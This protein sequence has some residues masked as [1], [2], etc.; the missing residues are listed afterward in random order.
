MVNF[1]SRN[2]SETEIE[3]LSLG[4]NF[5]PQRN[6][7]QKLEIMTQVERCYPRLAYRDPQSAH[8]FAYE[9][10]AVLKKCAPSQDSNLSR[11]EMLAV[12]TLSEDKSIVITPADKGNVTVVL[13]R[14]EYLDSGFRM[15]DDVSTY[16]RMRFPLISKGIG[17]LS[18][19][20]EELKKRGKSARL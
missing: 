9:V 1:S 20:L 19:A 12:R 3:V 8:E 6:K 5:V 4:L 13:D 18:A 2:L 15:L 16:K 10:A 17:E 14:Q 7:D 11:E